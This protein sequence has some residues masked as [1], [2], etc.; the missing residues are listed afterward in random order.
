MGIT[1][2]D[3]LH[4]RSIIFEAVIVATTLGL[5]SNAELRLV[6]QE[7]SKESQ[8][9]AIHQWNRQQTGQCALHQ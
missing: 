5:Q 8:V 4:G 2:V 9:Q 3:T 7:H 6:P 1:L